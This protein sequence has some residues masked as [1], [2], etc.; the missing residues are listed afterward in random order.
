MSA[1]RVALHAIP[2]R[3]SRG[4]CPAA[5]PRREHV[6][7][8]IPSVGYGGSLVSQGQGYHKTASKAS[9]PLEAPLTRRVGRP[10]ESRVAPIRNCD[11]VRSDTVQKI[12]VN[13]P[14][15]IPNTFYGFGYLSDQLEQI[16]ALASINM[17]AKEKPYKKRLFYIQGILRNRTGCSNTI[18]FLEHLYLSGVGMGWLE[19]RAKSVDYITHF[20]D[21]L[22]VW[23]KKNGTPWTGGRPWA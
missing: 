9:T 2:G 13:I 5:N 20:V 23:L 1:S 18:D 11:R 19:E 6:S 4:W 12:W 7:A 14:G 22:L 10:G 16:G 15:P 21:P 8:C 17:E 3:G